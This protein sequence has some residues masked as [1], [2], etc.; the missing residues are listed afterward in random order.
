MHCLGF[1]YSYKSVLVVE[2][3]RNIFLS[4]LV[5]LQPENDWAREDQD[6]PVLSS[7]RAPHV[8]GPAVV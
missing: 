3:F 2:R 7:E 4:P 5:E 6:R 1:I 8:N